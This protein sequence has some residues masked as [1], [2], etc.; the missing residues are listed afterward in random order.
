VEIYVDA[1]AC[2]VKEE[3]LRVAERHDIAVYMVANSWMRLEQSPLIKQIIVEE[4]ADVADDWIVEHIASGDIVITGDIPLASR[5]LE[6]MAYVL[7]NNG[8]PFTEANIGNAL[9]MRELKAQLRESGEI[10]GYN[11]SYRKT[12]RSRFLQALEEMA[13]RK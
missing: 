12:D 13:R 4:G 1:D 8:K 2:P 9:A 6:K 3:V 11:P 5:A 7:G 10:K